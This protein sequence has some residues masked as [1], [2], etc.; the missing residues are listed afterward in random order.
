MKH[1]FSLKKCPSYKNDY[2]IWNLDLMKIYSVYLKYFW[3]GKYLTSYKG[4]PDL[5]PYNV[6]I[7]F[8]F[9]T[10][11]GIVEDI[12]VILLLSKASKL[13]RTLKVTLRGCQLLSSVFPLYFEFEIE[14]AG[15]LVGVEFLPEH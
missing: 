5:T 15:P 12:F 13:R 7:G 1:Q 9:S 10:L 3:Y 4:N 11:E 6:C 2:M 8:S 14:K